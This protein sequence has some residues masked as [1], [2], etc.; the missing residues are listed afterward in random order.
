MGLLN[1]KLSDWTAND[2]LDVYLAK[3]FAERAG[4]MIFKA[5]LPT[6]EEEE[7]FAKLRGNLRLGQVPEGGWAQYEKYGKYIR[8]A[9]IIITDDR[10]KHPENWPD[11]LFVAPQKESISGTAIL[12]GVLWICGM[13]VVVTVASYFMKN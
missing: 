11:W 9:S 12:A 7:L 10:D 2:A 8:E 1:K 13:A 6:E 5:V 4:G 3:D